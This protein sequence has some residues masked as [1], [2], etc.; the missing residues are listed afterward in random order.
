MATMTHS[1]NQILSSEQG[2]YHWPERNCITTAMALYEA[3][4]T[5]PE[6]FFFQACA[7]YFTLSEEVAWRELAKLGGPLVHHEAIFGNGARRVTELAP[8]D[9][10]FLRGPIT[11]GNHSFAAKPGREGMAFVDEGYA[12][13]HWT[14][15]G[16]RPVNAPYPDYNALR[17][18]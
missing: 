9:I 6:P 15:D 13:L 16:L 8:G 5:K 17:M 3:L 10:V 18:V 7:H 2:V 1:V 4:C 14:P 12:V 11:M